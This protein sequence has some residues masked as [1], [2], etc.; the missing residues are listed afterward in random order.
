VTRDIDSVVIRPHEPGERAEI[1]ELLVESG[2]PTTGVEALG[3]DLFVAA[4]GRRVVGC[5][6]LERHGGVGLLRSVAVDPAWRGSG[7]GARLTRA[8]LALAEQAGVER[9]YLLTETAPDFFRGF[10]FRPIPRN[11]ADAAV[12]ASA[13]FAELCPTSATVMVSGPDP[14]E[15]V[16]P[17]SEAAPR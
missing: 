17:R 7:L 15:P 3:A 8:V 13:E 9:V 12:R 5:A 2:L 16:S 6:G 4:A 1:V 14:A 11:E 10:G